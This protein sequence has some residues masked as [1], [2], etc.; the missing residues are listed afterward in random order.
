MARVNTVEENVSQYWRNYFASHPRLVRVR[1][2]DKA[3]AQWKADHPDMPEVP[4]RVLNGLTN[5]KSALRKNGKGKRGRGRP[6]HGASTANGTAPTTKV[7]TKLLETL[8]D[9]IDRCLALIDGN[10]ALGR[11]SQALKH[12]RRLTIMK[13][14]E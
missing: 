5:V 6:P 12:A 11:V 7:P 9:E 1:S 8:E 10:K 14:I 4:Q 2:N 3:V 13:M